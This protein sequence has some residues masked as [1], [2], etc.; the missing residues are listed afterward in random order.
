VNDIAIVRTYAATDDARGL[1][2]E[3]EAALAVDYPPEQR[4][5][6]SFDAIFQPHVRFFVAPRASRGAAVRL[7]R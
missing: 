3:L 2:D 5:G 6:H 4:H 1:V 7:R